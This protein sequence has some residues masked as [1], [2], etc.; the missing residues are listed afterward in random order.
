MLSYGSVCSGIEAAHF[1]FSPLGYKQV[2]SSEI[3]IFPTKILQHYYPDVPNLGNMV[4][5]PELIMSEEVDAPDI[6]CGGTPCQAFS[7]AGWKNGLEDDRGLLTMKFIEIADTIDIVRAKNNKPS[8]VI[9]W[10]NVE[11]V[12]NDRTNAFGNFIGGLSGDGQEISSNGKWPKSGFYEGATRRVAWRVLDSKYFGLPHQRKRL[13]V[14]ATDKQGHPD[15]VLFEFGNPNRFDNIY[16]SKFSRKANLF[17]FKDQNTELVFSKG[18]TKFEVFRDYTDC[19]YAAYGTKWNGNAAAYNGSLYVAQD[20]RIRRLIPEECELLM[21][22]PK[23]YTNI[24]GAKHTTRYQGTGNSWAIPVVKWIGERLKNKN[25]ESNLDWKN[26]L[27]KE[28]LVSNGFFYRFG[29]KYPLNSDVFI[30]TTVSKNTPVVGNMKSII[31]KNELEK[32]YISA[33]ACRGILRRKN[34]RSLN[35]NKRLEILMENQAIELAKT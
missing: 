15:Q 14:V 10:E 32:F 18:G 16:N 35:M 33:K 4:G 8:S 7:L 9:L 21:G 24:E 34:E 31:C 27:R 1:A 2:W 23:G 11:G 6:F 13:Y 26:I 19:L 5:L 22:F 12:L 3:A 28:K 29:D 30:N 17:D 20:D 25:K